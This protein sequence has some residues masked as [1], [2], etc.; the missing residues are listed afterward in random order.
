MCDI[1]IVFSINK[2]HSLFWFR[3]FGYGLS[4]KNTEKHPLL[5][6]ERNGHTKTIRIRNWSIKFLKKQ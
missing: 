1:N 4:F 5:F 2:D 3:I 6:S